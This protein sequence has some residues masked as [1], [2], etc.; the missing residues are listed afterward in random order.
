MPQGGCAPCRDLPCVAMART[1]IDGV[2]AAPHFSSPTPGGG[3]TPGIATLFSKLKGARRCICPA[4]EACQQGG[5][6]RGEAGRGRLSGDSIRTF[7]IVLPHLV[8]HRGA[9]R[10]HNQPLGV[11]NKKNYIWYKWLVNNWQAFAPGGLCTHHQPASRQARRHSTQKIALEHITRASRGRLPA[12]ARVHTL[13]GAALVFLHAQP[14]LSCGPVKTAP[15]PPTHPPSPC[16]SESAHRNVH[17]T[18]GGFGRRHRQRSRE[19]HAAADAAHTRRRWP[20]RR[21]AQGRWR[22][23]PGATGCCLGGQ[24]AMRSD[25]PVV[26][27]KLLSGR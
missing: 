14:M 22:L 13:A 18:M 17:G 9:A 5:G 11:E 25:R 20:A 4:A 10:V 26:P 6:W 27:P 15:L 16:P 7:I 1:K 8:E 24:A 3:A 12:R 21:S 2:W 19:A 23:A